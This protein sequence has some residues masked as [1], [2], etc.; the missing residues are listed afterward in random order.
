MDPLSK[1]QLHEIAVRRRG[2]PDV[3]ALLLEI[4]RLHGTL[5]RVEAHVSNLPHY[6]DKVD[7]TL[8]SIVL[9]VVDLLA[10][11]PGLL[12]E[13]LE[14]DVKPETEAD[15]AE[16]RKLLEAGRQYPGMTDEAALKRLARDR[17][18]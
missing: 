3:K 10:E 8:H 2:D 17:R 12:A 16:K 6:A 13:V 14:I 1:E 5:T 9:R 4:K 11:E 15:R 7:V 18:G